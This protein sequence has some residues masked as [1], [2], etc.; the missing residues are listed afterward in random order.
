MLRCVKDNF[1]MYLGMMVARI[2]IEYPA[3]VCIDMALMCMLDVAVKS[4]DVE[5]DACCTNN[6]ILKFRVMSH[7]LESAV[8]RLPSTCLNPLA[9]INARKTQVIDTHNVK[10]TLECLVEIV[11]ECKCNSCIQAVL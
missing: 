1:I 9:T 8:S 3:A 5:R 6:M 2:K 4:E 11:D 7:T 10:I